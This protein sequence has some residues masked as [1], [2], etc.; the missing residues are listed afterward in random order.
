MDSGQNAI[1]TANADIT[2]FECDVSI[3]KSITHLRKQLSDFLE[4]LMNAEQ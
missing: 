2:A 4:R 1:F 3:Y